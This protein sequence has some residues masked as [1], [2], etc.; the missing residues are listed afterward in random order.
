MEKIKLSSKGQLVLPKPLRDTFGWRQGMQFSVEPSE[1]GV[2]L[3]P[4]Q[5]FK[6]TRLRD[7]VGSARYTGKAV[8]TT[9]M[10]EAIRKGM[11]SRRAHGRFDGPR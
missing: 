7:V 3:R 6:T 11:R 1:D 5:C 2:L 9:D 4:L 10:K 8:S